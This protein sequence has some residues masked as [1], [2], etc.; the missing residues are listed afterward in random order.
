MDLIVSGS[1]DAILMVECGADGVTEAEVLDAL[2]IAHGE[3]KKLVGAMEELAEKAGK[4]KIEVEAPVDRRGAARQDHRRASAPSSTRPRRS[5][6][7]SSARTRSTAVKDEVARALAPETGDEEADAAA[8]RRG[9]APLRRSSRRTM[10][11]KRIA[12][13]KKRPDGRGPGRDPADRDRGRHRARACTARRCSPAARRRSSPTSRSARR[14]W[15]CGSTTSACRRPRRFMHHYNF[16]PFSVGEAGFMR[17]PKRRDIGHGALAERAL[18][19]DD[20]RPGGLPVHDPGRLRDARVERLLVDGLGLRARRW[21]C[22]T[23]A[24]RSPRRS[25]A[26]R[27]A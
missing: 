6:T 23:P 2:D 14:G 13:D 21:R 10:I 11:R 22:R 27:W 12:V 17:G 7:S 26:S 20:P 3:I 18:R 8:Q 16:P 25:R 4:E 15:T 1:K 19:A 24:C 5:R 9:H